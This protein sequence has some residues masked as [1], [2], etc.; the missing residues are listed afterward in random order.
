MGHED[1]SFD[2]QFPYVT[3]L[4]YEIIWHD[5]AN[6]IIAYHGYYVMVSCDDHDGPLI[7]MTAL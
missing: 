7:S 5:F 2:F 4:C 1:C 3:F 6:A